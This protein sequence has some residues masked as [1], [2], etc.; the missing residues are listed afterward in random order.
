MGAAPIRG[1]LGFFS[2]SMGRSLRLDA[3]SL[4]LF[5]LRLANGIEVRYGCVFI[6]EAAWSGKHSRKGSNKS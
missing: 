5:G 4:M 1:R 6:S 2:V 3:S